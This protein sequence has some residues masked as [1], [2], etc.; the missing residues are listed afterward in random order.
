MEASSLT[1]QSYCPALVIFLPSWTNGVKT[2]VKKQCCKSPLSPPMKAKAPACRMDG[3]CF[4]CPSH[5]PGIDGPSEEHR[6][7]REPRPSQALQRDLWGTLCSPGTPG[8]PKHAR[9]PALKPHGSCPSLFVQSAHLQTGQDKGGDVPAAPKGAVG[10]GHE[11][12][13]I[14]Q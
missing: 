7:Q 11:Q 3:L 4:P 14:P 6:S 9:I 8:P 12:G 5:P 10:E 1:H 2:Q 13:E